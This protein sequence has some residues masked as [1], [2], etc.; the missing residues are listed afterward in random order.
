[1]KVLTT[2]N[3]GVS[4]F[5]LVAVAAALFA[6]S[7]AA[8]ATPL[9][10]GGSIFP[11]TPVPAPS[12]TLLAS[13]SSPFSSSSLVGTLFSQV[14]QDT[15]NPFGSGML[16]FTY[17]IELSTSSPNSLSQLSVGH[18][19]SFL[20]DAGYSV[21]PGGVAPT[22]F[23]RSNE[24]GGR[25]DVLQLHFGPLAFGSD[26]LQPGQNSDLL[27]IR[28]SASAFS[29]TTASVIDGVAVPNIATFTPVPE[30]SNA[31]LLGLGTAIALIWRRGFRR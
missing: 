2:K 3:P 12:G 8:K 11:V 31:A 18:Y 22:F 28:T 14:W 1:M 16:T 23:G 20:V 29:Q 21:L 6:S 9:L 13:L 19:D 5:H 15:G 30:P 7:L 17:R 25:G 10:P 24:G 27:V 4:A 26:E